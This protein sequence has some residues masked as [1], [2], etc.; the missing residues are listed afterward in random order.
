MN[1]TCPGCGKQN[2]IP[3]RHLAHT[4]RCG[5]CKTSLPAQGEPLEVD[6]VQFQQIISDSPV[7]V[8]V[9][10][11]AGWCQPCRLAAPQV[12]QAARTMAGKAVVVK[13]DTE[14]HPELS[15]RHN[16]RGIPHFMVFKDGQ[17]VRSQS[18]L[19]DHQQLISWLQRAA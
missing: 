16:V 14:R 5:A 3:A 2:R 13:V 9:D 6:P 10:F 11:W 8:L 19:V 7:P 4:G 18:G 12:Q 17:V 15:A 1:R